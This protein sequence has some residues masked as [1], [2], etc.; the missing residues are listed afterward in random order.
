MADEV[1]FEAIT[2]AQLAAVH[3]L[4][5]ESRAAVQHDILIAT[6][7][8]LLRSGPRTRAELLQEVGQVWPGAGLDNGRLQ[9][10]LTAAQIANLVAQAELL[11]GTGWALTELGTAEVDASRDW[12]SEALSR[13]QDELHARAQRGGLALTSAAEAV[14]WTGILS[15]ALFIGIRRASAAYMG[16]VELLADDTLAPRA[17]HSVSMFATIRQAT[18]A[19]PEVTEFLEAMV[20]AAIDPSDPFGNELVSH[21]A[22]GY[23]LHAIVARRDRMQA[24]NVLGSLKGERVIL[25]TP[26]LFPLLG[27]RREAEPILQLVQ[28]SVAAGIEVVVAD[29]T[30]DE[31]IDVLKRLS[32]HDVPAVESA[33]KEGIDPEALAAFLDEPILQSWLRGCDEGKYKTWSDFEQAAYDLPLALDQLGVHRRPHHNNTEWDHVD[34]LSAALAAELDRRGKGRGKPQIERDANTLAM[35]WRKRRTERGTGR[36][37]PAAWVITTDTYMAPTYRALER[38]DEFPI[39]VTPS[40]WLGMVSSCCDPPSVEELAESAAQL[41]A[42]ET[43]L[44]IAAKYPPSVA[45]G[46]ARALSELDETSETDIRVAQLSLDDIL[47]DYPDIMGDPATTGAK[48]A[49]V[50]VGMRSQRMSLAY[51]R[52]SERLIS[53]QTRAVA[54]A[55]AAAG[56]AEAE[57]TA[58]AEAEA[59]ALTAGLATEAE[60]R[61]RSDDR[62]L[63][64]RREVRTGVLIACLCVTALFAILT[65]WPLAIGTALTAV[66]FLERAI[67]WVHDVNSSWHRLLIAPLGE[68]VALIWLVVHLSP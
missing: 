18:Q 19:R 20:V 12:A 52:G 47:N 68:V 57:R 48:F 36:F 59:R 40:Q 41:L 2:L 7:L 29:H 24:R 38:S 4:L 33:L 31:L 9:Q 35:T 43:M 22:T 67:D 6:I 11:S 10:S 62:I 16:D 5:D 58:R 28:T 32:T 61:A 39:A 21:I 13:T 26:L 25:D 65:L 17:F 49:S 27:P 45:I 30:L 55:E 60:K 23:M 8:E 51:S 34:E 53:D 63:A 44:S 37:W 64:R 54:Q 1:Q 42:Q 50:V 66:F 3:S 15:D 14:L 56:A 46:I